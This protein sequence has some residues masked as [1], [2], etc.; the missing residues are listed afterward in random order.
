[1]EQRERLKLI[2]DFREARIKIISLPEAPARLPEG[3][4]LILHL[5]PEKWTE[6]PHAFYDGVLGIESNEQSAPLSLSM[7]ETLWPQFNFDG[8]IMLIKSELEPGLASYVQ[9]F[10]NGIIES[11]AAIQKEG[12]FA[13]DQVEKEL[14][15][16]IQNYLEIQKRIGV[17][18]PVFGVLSIVGIQG[19]E[20][21]ASKFGKDGLRLPPQKIKTYDQYEEAPH[22]VV[23]PMFH[24]MWSATGRAGSP[25][26]DKDGKFKPR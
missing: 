19:L 18:A 9:Y 7:G 21:G 8:K 13:P 23:R 10:F 6:E 17:K 5:I 14:F 11:V 15:K 3:G 12:G 20:G 25:T 22:E 16:K 1:M 4:R 24:R 2:E 26:F